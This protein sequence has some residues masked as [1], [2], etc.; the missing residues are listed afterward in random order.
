MEFNINSLDEL[1]VAAKKISELFTHKII[2]L[3]GEMGAGKTTLIKELAVILGSSDSTGSPTFSLVNEYDIPN[4]KIYHFDLYRVKSEE[5]ALDFGVEEYLYS[6]EYCFIE[7]P[8]I[9]E[10]LLPDEYHL[11]EIIVE[12]N[13]RR[14]KFV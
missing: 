13:Q 5:E 2:L 1:S 12:N 8:E 6:G 9:I 7:W 3:K 10:G 11:I 4:G 14:I